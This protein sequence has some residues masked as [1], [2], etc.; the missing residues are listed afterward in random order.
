MTKTTA[1]LSSVPTS[2]Q[3][4][5]LLLQSNPEIAQRFTE[6]YSKSAKKLYVDKKH[7]S[8]IS[9]Y[10]S[11]AD[12]YRKGKFYTHI[13]VNGK[14]RTVEKKT[15]E[16]LYE[17]LYDYYKNEEE[18]PKTY[19]EV[20]RLLMAE[21]DK[22]GIKAATILEYSRINGHL[23]QNIRNKVIAYITEEE[24]KDWL[25]H[26]YLKEKNP[27]K[28]ALKKMIQLINAVFEFGLENQYCFNNPAKRIHWKSYAK[29]CDFSSKPK[30]EKS[31]SV[32]Q[33]EQLRAYCLKDIKNPH[34]I[35][36]L[37]SME[38]G[39]RV[40]ELPVLRKDD[41]DLE[42]GFIH[43]HRQ[44]V[45]IP[46]TQKEDLYFTEVPYCKNEKDNPQDGRLVPITR[47]CEEALKIALAMPGDSEYVF[48]YADGRPALK[49]SYLHYLRRVCARLHI[50]ISNNHAMRI[51]FN[52]RLIRKGVDIIDRSQVLGHTPETN[53]RHY[54]YSDKRTAENV[55]KKLNA[56]ESE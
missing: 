21:K 43:V 20:F 7:T 52:D 33:L 12:K 5:M 36:M 53:E 34:A 11:T 18:Q 10:L 31:F 46:K 22:N 14:R 32:T 45:R 27:K 24:L 50:P 19:D 44:Q 1:D 35:M 40:G 9:Q 54:S 30:E 13:T 41:I 6:M 2:E 48:H 8:A 4:L 56:I 47:K 51:A 38:T 16:E 3:E 17:Y 28:E 55:K 37:V 49:D 39:M 29:Y 42:S 25:M 23:A 26:I 15:E